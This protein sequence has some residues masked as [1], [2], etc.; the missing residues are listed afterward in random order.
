MGRVEQDGSGR[1]CT[2][3][4]SGTRRPRLRARAEAAHD[5]TVTP[6]PPS[7]KHPAQGDDR[8]PWIAAAMLLT[9]SDGGQARDPWWGK[10][11]G[12]SRSLRE[13]LDSGSRWAYE[14]TLGDSERLGPLEP[15]NRVG[16]EV[17]RE[18]HRVDRRPP[19]R[20]FTSRPSPL[21]RAPRA[22]SSGRVRPIGRGHRPLPPSRVS[23]Q[24]TPPS[25]AVS[26]SRCPRRR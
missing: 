9:N 22:E 15:W 18:R 2:T 23:R 25:C 24:T 4:K 3:R 13:A 11:A 16:E 26:T 17:F 12:Q 14:H 19:Q 21:L 7:P 20:D 8:N 5:G 10:V 6:H 1:L